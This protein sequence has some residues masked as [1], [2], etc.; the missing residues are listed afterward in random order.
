MILVE[1]SNIVCPDDFSEA[2]VLVCGGSC[3][4]DWLDNEHGCHQADADAFCK[5][6][7]CDGNAKAKEKGYKK[8]KAPKGVPGFSCGRRGKKHTGIWFGIKDVRYAPDVRRTNGWTDVV[9]NIE[10]VTVGMYAWCLNQSKSMVSLTLNTFYTNCLFF[11][12]KQ[13][14]FILSFRITIAGFQT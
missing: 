7:L 1:Q 5:L 6:S 10:C 4:D 2:K 8:I 11:Q 9:S 13:Q 14:S 3:G 12:C